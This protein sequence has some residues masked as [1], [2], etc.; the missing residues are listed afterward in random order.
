MSRVAEDRR[1]KIVG[2]FCHGCG[3]V[4][5][6]YK[7]RHTGDALHGKDHIS[8]PC[9]H[10]GEEFEEAVD[11]WEAAIEVLPPKQEETPAAS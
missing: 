8:S 9:S 4:Y 1:G 10:E 7:D 2:R 3:S 6:M 5:S 11:W